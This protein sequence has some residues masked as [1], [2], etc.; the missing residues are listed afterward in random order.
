[1]ADTIH[2]RIRAARE[3][4]GLSQVDVA[5]ELGVTPQAVHQWE[6]RK[7]PKGENLRKLATLYGCS[8]D[9]FENGD[10][11]NR[12]SIT[13]LDGVSLREI[14]LIP[15][16]ELVMVSQAS[17]LKAAKKKLTT[18][19][20]AGPNSFAFIVEDTSMEPEVRKGEAVIIDKDLA[21]EPGDFIVA[22]IE[23]ENL[24]VY[25]KFIYD[26][27]DHCRLIPINEA[28]RSYRFPLDAWRTKVRVIG[29]HVQQIAV[30]RK[31]Q[32]N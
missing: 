21:V 19:F 9:H 30:G 5:R 11:N 1:M 12:N 4:R 28:H 20:H 29:V 13:P 7:R 24:T 25:R 26:G 3:R 14:P 22:F 31:S 10:P 8:I 18:N 6:V 27:P 2:Q 32:I 23:G 15:F 17:D 16:E